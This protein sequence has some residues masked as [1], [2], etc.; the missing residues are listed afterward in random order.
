MF[1]LKYSNFFAFN[2]RLNKLFNLHIGTKIVAKKSSATS[3]T[4]TKSKKN[5]YEI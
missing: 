2:L 4:K 5:T 3:E 1:S